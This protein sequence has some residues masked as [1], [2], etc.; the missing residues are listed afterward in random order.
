MQGKNFFINGMCSVYSNSISVCVKIYLVQSRFRQ[1]NDPAYTLRETGPCPGNNKKRGVAF[2]SCQYPNLFK[3]LTV[4]GRTLRNRIMS[5]PNMLFQVV[6]GRPTDYY[7][8][9]LEHKAKGGAAI[10]NMGE[11]PICDGGSH[12][13]Q[14]KLTPENLNIFGEIASSIKQHGALA[15]V[16]LT[17]GGRR[18]RQW[19]NEKQ[20]IGPV[21]E[22]TEMGTYVV[23][24]TEQDMEDVANA[25]ADAAAYAM[26]AGFD[27]AMVLSG[28][29]WLFTQFLSP[30][31]NK[32][33]DQYG[34]SL[35][36][37]MRFPLM[38]LKRMREKVRNGMIL[39]LRM[40]GNERAEGG[41]TSED[42]AEFL[43]YAQ[44][45]VDLVEITTEGW[46]YCMPSTY[47]PWALNREFAATIKKTGKVHIPLFL[48]GSIVSPEMAE[49]IIT[50]GDADGV[51]LSRALIADPAMPIKA[52]AGRIDEITPCLRCLRCTDGDNATRFFRCSVNPCTAH[53]TRVGFME[54]IKPALNKKN[55]LVIGAGPGG[56]S[57]AVTAAKRGHTVTLLEKK[58]IV[59]GTIRYARHDAMKPDLQR[60]L[61]YLEKLPYLYDN[62]TVKVNT[63]CTPEMVDE[64]KPDHIIVATGG[65]PI[66]ATFIKGYEKAH[67]I[68]DCYFKPE[69]VQGDNI[70]I[71][72]G[73]LSGVEA[74][75][76]MAYL[77]K[78]VT[79]LEMFTCLSNVGTTYGWGVMSAV[80]KYG[81]TL[82]NGATVKEVTDEGVL[83]VKDGEEQL[84]KADTV[85]YA[86]GMR[87]DSTL[88]C[89]IADKAP[90]VDII[91]D[92]AQSARIGEA[93]AGGYYAALDIG[94][95]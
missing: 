15:S 93:V 47:V 71:I 95:F 81:V 73:G 41:F 79:V 1:W 54:D 23:A 88:F 89:E 5:A 86:V 53:E 14:I 78:K 22:I 55:V 52:R 85:F 29:S 4:R 49:E 69:T 44:E 10:V 7:V 77:G 58:D 16:E 38:C 66:T 61:D 42:I 59:G 64:L 18:A 34:G 50:S 84:Q 90:F 25:Y 72:G 70:T 80:E 92:A 33:T 57:A 83:Y 6:N 40:S 91:G 3:P 35:E 60:Y 67:E 13:P 9:Y 75:I 37:R 32:R 8:G 51:S 63:E 12:T 62:I 26:S 24:M 68:L 56:I 21:T 39:A 20:V 48:I 36:N 11:I 82:V 28:H 87:S 31:I 94:T 46:L 74:G 43:S 30:L 19:Y 2:M 27:M 76:H 65:K 45:Y 17:H